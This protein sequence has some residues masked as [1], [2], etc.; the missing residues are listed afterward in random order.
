M[1]PIFGPAFVERYQAVKAF[2]SSYGSGACLP[3]VRCNLNGVTGVGS[4]LLGI[5]QKV[6][7][8][9]E[10]E[11]WEWRGISISRTTG[12]PINENVVMHLAA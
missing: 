8:W 10:D 6:E 4:N 7:E 12:I 11:S 9:G 1:R 5:G 2:D 3:G